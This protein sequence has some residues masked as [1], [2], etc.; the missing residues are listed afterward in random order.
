MSSD[1]ATAQIVQCPVCP[2]R[3]QLSRPG[4]MVPVGFRFD[5]PECGSELEL[6]DE[7]TARVVPPDPVALN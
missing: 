7:R 5:C 1:R 4:G 6:I 2:T 3:L